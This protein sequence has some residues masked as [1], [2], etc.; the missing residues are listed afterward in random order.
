ANPFRADSRARRRDIDSYDRSASGKRR[1]SAVCVAGGGKFALMQVARSADTPRVISSTSPIDEPPIIPRYDTAHY[2]SDVSVT[3]TR[4]AVTVPQ[5]AVYASSPMVAQSPTGVIFRTDLFSQT[6]LTQ[7]ITRDGQGAVR[8][9]I[10]ATRAGG[11]TMG[12]VRG[13]VN[14]VD[15]SQEAGTSGA[16]LQR[17]QQR[18]FINGSLSD[19]A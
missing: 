7:S 16:P 15:T 13:A 12:E 6:P 17:Q 8:T 18:Q 5:R 3:R 2:P 11:T 14:G 9:I 19:H 4:T 1:R 10:T